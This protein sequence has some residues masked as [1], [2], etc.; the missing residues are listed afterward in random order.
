[1]EERARRLANTPPL[2][3]DMCKVR[4]APMEDPK[5]FPAMVALMQDLIVL[6]F[7][8]DVTRVVTWSFGHALGFR[9]YSFIGVSGDSHACTHHGGDA[10]KIESAKKID[11]WRIQQLAAMIQKLKAAKDFDG[12]NI[13]H[14]TC[15]YYTSEIGDGDPHLQSNKPII[16]AGRLG[17]FLRTGQVVECSPRDSSGR[18][19]ECGVTRPSGCSNTTASGTE[20]ASFYVSLLRAYGL[21]IDKFGQRG[22]GP[23]PSALL[24]KISTG[25]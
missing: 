22:A 10:A 11:L 5:D 8:C 3:S 19:K 16:L 4:P 21:P 9:S 24:A 6:A 12:N 18:F 2:S 13:L 15:L 25:A 17:G 14:N 7:Q 23:L 20:L 1:V